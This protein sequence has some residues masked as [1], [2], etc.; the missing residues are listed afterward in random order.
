MSGGCNRAP[1]PRWEY[2]GDRL[3][4]H[5]W[6]AARRP[7]K[8]LDWR[9]DGRKLTLMVE[10]IGARRWLNIDADELFCFRLGWRVIVALAIK[11]CRGEIGFTDRIRRVSKTRGS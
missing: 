11:R 10:A 8:G 7:C 9:F 5:R 2:P 1:G 3:E 6:C 4:F